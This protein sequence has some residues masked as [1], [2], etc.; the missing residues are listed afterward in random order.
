MQT[1]RGK[2]ADRFVYSLWEAL[3]ALELRTLVLPRRILGLLGQI[4]AL[5]ALS[6]FFL[7]LGST[8]AQAEAQDLK[9]SQAVSPNLLVS[10]NN[11]TYTITVT[12]SPGTVR[13]TWTLTDVLPAGVTFVSAAAAQGTCSQSCG[14]VTC[15][16][17][18][19]SDS[20]FTTDTVNIVVRPMS[21]ASW[22]NLVGVVG[23][24]SIFD[25]NMANNTSSIVTVGTAPTIS[26]IVPVSGPTA[27]GTP[28]TIAGTNFV[29]GAT[30]KIGSLRAAGVAFVSSTAL[31]G[32]TP[33]QP[34]GPASVVVTNPNSETA[35]LPQA[36]T[37]LAPTITSVSPTSGPIAGGTVVT[38]TGANFVSGSII[39]FGG[40][41]ATGVTW[42]S[43]TQLRGTTPPHVAGPADVV[44]TGP[45]GVSATRANGFTFLGPLPTVAS[46]SP[47]SGPVAGG[48]AVTITG[49]NF[50]S[51]TTVSIGGVAAATVALLSSTKIACTT[52]AHAA[53]AVDIVVTNIDGQAATL[54]SGF[55]YVG[56]PPTV[57]AISPSIGS[58]AGGTVVT[59]TGTNF[60]TRVSLNIGGVNATDV[61]RLSATQIRGT[62]GAHPV[63]V[64]GVIVLNPGLQIGQLK[65]SFTYVGPGPTLASITPNSG[66]IAGGTTVTLKGSNFGSGST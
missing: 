49:T 43:A 11:L 22:T 47:L 36:F 21:G 31:Q 40:T 20:L 42:L 34:A 32:T 5:T 35:T 25:P 65:N 14:I 18:T 53:G 8:A 63:G 27:G 57:T 59:V 51:G 6:F 56:P 24:P 30:V 16:L 45:D 44:M 64:V 54:P 2:A 33:A 61:T 48:T 19:S 38:L 3:I 41:Q 1:C 28:F 46:V 17:A 55:A 60:A 7:Y 62:T 29:A 50:A 4:V 39:N 58:M 12:A 23:D 13:S 37:Y 66:P 52:A 10:G 15:S 26:T 9:V